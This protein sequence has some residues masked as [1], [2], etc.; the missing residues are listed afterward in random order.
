MVC[1][2]DLCNRAKEKDSS[3]VVKSYR[4]IHKYEG[5]VGNCFVAHG[6]EGAGGR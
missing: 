5:K 1:P 2:L 3:A 6:E 4:T